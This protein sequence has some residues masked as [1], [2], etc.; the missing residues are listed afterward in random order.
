MLRGR[1]FSPKPASAEMGNNLLLTGNEYDPLNRE[2]KLTR[3]NF[4]YAKPTQYNPARHQQVNADQDPKVAAD[5]G[6]Y[7]DDLR[8]EAIAKQSGH[9]FELSPGGKCGVCKTDHEGHVKIDLIKNKFLNALSNN[10][11]SILRDKATGQYQYEIH[12]DLDSSQGAKDD[13]YRVSDDEMDNV[14]QARQK[15][16]WAKSNIKDE[17][18]ND[19]GTWDATLPGFEQEKTPEVPVTI[20]DFDKTNTAIS[21][22]NH[23]S[24][25]VDH[26]GHVDDFKGVLKDHE[27]DLALIEEE[28]ANHNKSLQDAWARKD[29][30]AADPILDAMEPLHKEL[31][32]K[33]EDIEGVKKS[34]AWHQGQIESRQKAIETEHNLPYYKPQRAII[35][36]TGK[37][38]DAIY[39]SK[40]SRNQRRRDESRK[41]YRDQID[42]HTQS[43]LDSRSA[44]KS[45][46]IDQ[47]T[48]SANVS[49]ATKAIADT[50]AKLNGIRE[51]SFAE[52]AVRRGELRR[53]RSEQ[54]TARTARR[55]EDIMYNKKLDTVEEAADV[56]GYDR[57]VYDA[58]T[59]TAVGPRN[60][61]ELLKVMDQSG[62]Y[63]FTNNHTDPETGEIIEGGKLVHHTPAQSVYAG[64]D[65]QEETEPTGTK[66]ENL[67][68]KAEIMGRLINRSDISITTDPMKDELKRRI[69]AKE[70]SKDDYKAGIISK[71]QHKANMAEHN[72]IISSLKGRLKTIDRSK[73]IV[74]SRSPG[75]NIVNPGRF[76]TAGIKMTTFIDD[77]QF[78]HIAVGGNGEILSYRK[79]GSP[80]QDSP[81]FRM[82]NH[83]HSEACG[84]DCNQMDDIL[85]SQLSSIVQARNEQLDSRSIEQKFFKDYNYHMDKMAEVLKPHWKDLIQDHVAKYGITPETELYFSKR[86]K[87]DENGQA[88]LDENG[89]PQIEHVFNP[90]KAPTRGN[91]LN[92]LRF[93]VPVSTPGKVGIGGGTFD[94]KKVSGAVQKFPI[95]RA[96][97]LMSPLL[98][99]AHKAIV[100][101]D[102][103]SVSR[104]PYV[105]RATHV[106]D[107]DGKALYSPCQRKDCSA[108]KSR[109]AGKASAQITDPVCS[110][111]GQKNSPIMQI[112]KPDSLIEESSLQSGDKRIGILGALVTLVHKSWVHTEGE[113]RKKIREAAKAKLTEGLPTI[114]TGSQEVTTG[115]KVRG[116]K[117]HQL[118][119]ALV[120]EVTDVPQPAVTGNTSLDAVSNEVVSSISS[121][122]ENKPCEHCNRRHPSYIC[123]RDPLTTEQAQ[124]V[125]SAPKQPELGIQA[126]GR[127]PITMPHSFAPD[128]EGNC[129]HCG[130]DTH[131]PKPRPMATVAPEAPRV[132][133]PRFAE[134]EAPKA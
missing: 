99:M 26:M 53:Q 45:G 34:I 33:R 133:S 25:M 51:S 118:S 64:W 58:K 62:T 111:C 88:I 80:I 96:A 15:E 76:G 60:N 18:V 91:L 100:S 74:Y 123:D 55:N 84:K 129:V 94:F 132:L 32:Q 43:I 92:A 52:A 13:W 29:W 113:R 71:E 65:N 19:L 82:G 56:L 117:P 35:E 17:D 67:W 42:Q 30:D 11:L 127:E 98:T 115:K 37:D 31:K 131:N 77:P 119:D 112:S 48:H 85:H 81:I 73:G 27:D 97:A 95:R 57:Y 87:V 124:A 44:F 121:Q 102:G 70:K 24:A 2:F 66:L 116:T 41:K 5:L 114:E 6:A 3:S 104:A 9:K 23:V 90:P 50:Q 61:P 38:W 49:A 125:F 4:N 93:V 69:A 46:Q 75:S 107:E 16:N 89:E 83:T 134:T 47:D 68:S 130:L 63:I 108:G 54:A 39:L 21:L 106:L 40:I 109:L 128:E 101:K 78:G 120:S 36:P 72:P 122:Q 10:K 59:N 86:T 110:Q 22:Q 103:R 7:F 8:R 79:P 20:P 14:R 28:Y 126:A 1:Q 12:P 105:R